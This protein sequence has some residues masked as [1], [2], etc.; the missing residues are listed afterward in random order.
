M[1][2]NRIEHPSGNSDLV[3]V[4]KL[5]HKTLLPKAPQGAHHFDFCSIKGMVS[6]MDLLAREFVSSVRIRRAPALPRIF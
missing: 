6:V 5:D 2:K 3:S 4:G 1:A